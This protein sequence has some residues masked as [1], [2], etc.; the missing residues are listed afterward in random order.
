[1]EVLRVVFA[2]QIDFDELLHINVVLS[3]L[4]RKIFVRNELQVDQI[5]RS[6]IRIVWWEP[7]AKNVSA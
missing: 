7:N 2:Q 6:A 1:M 3:A 4:V 5:F